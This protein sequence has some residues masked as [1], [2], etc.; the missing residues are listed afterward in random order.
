MNRGEVWLVNFEPQTHKEEIAKVRPALI[1][2]ASEL[3]EC[4]SLIV[5]PFS[6]GVIKDAEPLRIHCKS[7]FLDRPSDL[8]LLQIRSVS[9]RRLVRKIGAFS[10]K[11]MQKVDRCVKE[12]LGLR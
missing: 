10:T 4:G 12:V 1:L 8:V 9:E 5:A 11:E 2:Q 6:S 3:N 7:T